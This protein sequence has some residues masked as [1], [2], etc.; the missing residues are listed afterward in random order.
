MI[1]QQRMRNGKQLHGIIKIR[2]SPLL[3]VL[4]GEFI[5]FSNFFHYFS[6]SHE[7]VYPLVDTIK[8]SA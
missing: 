3:R 1:K 6:L 4:S 2:N 7:V 5:I 8:H